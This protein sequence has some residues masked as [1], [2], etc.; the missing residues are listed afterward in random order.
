MSKK[1]VNE[2]LCLPESSPVLGLSFY[3]GWCDSLTCDTLRICGPKLSCMIVFGCF[4]YSLQLN[5]VVANAQK[6]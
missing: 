2:N 4:E 3:L 1:P 5:F 6:F